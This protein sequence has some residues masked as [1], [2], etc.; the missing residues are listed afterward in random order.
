MDDQ[1]SR[2]FYYIG[3]LAL[4]FLVAFLL[5]RTVFRG[6]EVSGQVKATEEP[7]E[8]PEDT[9]TLTTEEAVPD[10]ATTV[11]EEVDPGETETFDFEDPTEGGEQLSTGSF[12]EKL[13]QRVDSIRSILGEGRRRTDVILRYYPHLPDG[14][15]VYS[16]SD[17]GFYLHERPTDT[18][19]LKVPTN[20][21]YYGDNVP[22]ADIQLVA[23]ELIKRGVNIRLIKM[24]QFHDNWKA[25]SIEIGTETDAEALAVL[26]L[27]DIWRLRKEN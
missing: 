16:L 24:S 9:K 17:L 13:R 1:P 21:L 15:I 23:Y 20:A 10:E 8:M 27:E 14:E 12:E 4:I 19:L 3:V 5:T 18:T 11:E 26:S 25:N 7:K 6:N 2:A 22:L